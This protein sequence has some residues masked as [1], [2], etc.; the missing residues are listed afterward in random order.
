VFAFTLGFASRGFE[1]LACS[2][3]DPECVA[4]DG[5]LSAARGS[6]YSIAFRQGEPAVVK[7]HQDP[8]YRWRFCSAVKGSDGILLAKDMLGSR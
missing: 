4:R 2:A 5:H 8:Q 7:L 1:S 6:L 3:A